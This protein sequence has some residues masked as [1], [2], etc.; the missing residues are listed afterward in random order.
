LV[1]D[2]E[3]Y[4]NINLPGELTIG[5]AYTTRNMPDT[6][7]PRNVNALCKIKTGFGVS[8]QE[9]A[10]LPSIILYDDNRK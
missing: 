6:N 9:D 1:T 3:C 5:T 2:V 7:K 4:I 10:Y 8:M